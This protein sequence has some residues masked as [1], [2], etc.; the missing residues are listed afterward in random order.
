MS[1]ANQRDTEDSE[2]HRQQVEAE[3]DERIQEERKAEDE[4]GDPGPPPPRPRDDRC[5]R[6]IDDELRPHE[7]YGRRPDGPAVDHV[8]RRHHHRRILELEVPIRSAVLAGD[9]VE[10]TGVPGQD[11]VPAGSGRVRG[12]RDRDDGES[13]AGEEHE[14]ES[15]APGGHRCD[16]ADGR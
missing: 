6:E 5:D 15:E 12:E 10:A 13:H 3:V 16:L 1:T 9:L 7:P 11:A 2:K 8:D 14:E 4:V